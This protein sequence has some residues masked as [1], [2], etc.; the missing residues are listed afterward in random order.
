MAKW[1]CDCGADRELRSDGYVEACAACGAPE[2]DAY[3]AAIEMQE[4]YEANSELIEV[5]KA[6]E[7]VE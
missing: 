1:R 4:E 7:Y 5:A 3:Q 6:K 2:H